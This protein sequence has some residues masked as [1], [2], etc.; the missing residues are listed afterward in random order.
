MKPTNKM[1]KSPN[2][3]ALFFISLS[4][5]EKVIKKMQLIYVLCTVV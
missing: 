4:P 3:S 2:R 5:F 1:I